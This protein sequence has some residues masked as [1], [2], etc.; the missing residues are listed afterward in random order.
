MAR[1]TS[2]TGEKKRKGSILAS[3]K[4]KRKRKGSIL[5]SLREKKEEKRVHSSLPERERKKKRVH[6]SLPEREG[7]IP[8]RVYAPFLPPGYVHLLHPGVHPPSCSHGRCTSPCVYNGGCTSPCVYNGGY[9]LSCFIP[10]VGVPSLLL[11]PNGGCTSLSVC[12]QRWVYLSQCVHNGG[13]PSCFIPTV[14]YPSCFIPTV[15]RCSPVCYSLFN[16]NK[17]GTERSVSQGGLLST[18]GD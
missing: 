9:S 18:R 13:Y 11:Y 4:G 8:T 7:G 15:G 16:A 1:F 17:P 6:S 12:T 10:T 3:Q 14:G 2:E 5:A